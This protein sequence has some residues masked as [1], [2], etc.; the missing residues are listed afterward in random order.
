[1]KINY[2]DKNISFKLGN[3]ICVT[4]VIMFISVKGN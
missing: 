2:V 1:M 3:Y 4:C